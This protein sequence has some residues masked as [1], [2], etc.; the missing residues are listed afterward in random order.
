MS[1]EV[2]STPINMFL[3]SIVHHLVV[4]IAELRSLYD[5]V[6]NESFPSRN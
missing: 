5:S 4:P 2:G 1:S 6:I 3:V